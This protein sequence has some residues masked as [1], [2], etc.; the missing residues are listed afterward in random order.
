MVGVT[1]TGCGAYVTVR[2]LVKCPICRIPM[3]PIIGDYQARPEVPPTAPMPLPI[4]PP[5]IKVAHVMSLT[6]WVAVITIPAIVILIF[7]IAYRVIV[8]SESQ[9]QD[10]AINSVLYQCQKYIY[11]LALYGGSDMPPYTQNHGRK[12]EFYFAWPRGS[13]EFANAF[14]GREKMSAS[15]TGTISTGEIKHLTLNAKDIL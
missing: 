13:F 14:G 15:C 3:K 5:P 6:D 10:R 7:L 2:G 11:S 9:L 8:P 12:D 4:V 1:C